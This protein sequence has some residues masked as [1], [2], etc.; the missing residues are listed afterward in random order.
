MSGGWTAWQGEMASRQ[1]AAAG[2]LRELESSERAVL[3]VT[4]DLRTV[5]ATT[6]PPP[7]SSSWQ[8]H[9]PVCL[10]M[11][12]FASITQTMYYGRLPGRSICYPLV[13]PLI[14]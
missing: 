2:S 12:M 3:A 1:E 11:M 10:L 9:E 8:A 7:P 6:P 14:D 5:R 4:T 13:A